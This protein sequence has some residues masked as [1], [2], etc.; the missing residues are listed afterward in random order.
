MG[1]ARRHGRDRDVPEVDVFRALNAIDR[2]DFAEALTELRAQHPIG[3]GGYDL[4]PAD[5]GI[6]TAAQ[7]KRWLTE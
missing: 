2:N 7:F 1:R 4:T 5:V 3:P 6:D